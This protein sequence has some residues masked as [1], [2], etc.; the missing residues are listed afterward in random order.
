MLDLFNLRS[1]LFWISIFTFS[2][3]S[4]MT[5]LTSETWAFTLAS[6]LIS[7]GCST[8]YCICSFNL[9]LQQAQIRPRTTFPQATEITITTNLA[10]QA[11]T[12]ETQ[13]PNSLLRLLAAAVAAF[14]PPYLAIKS[15]FTRSRKATGTCLPIDSSATTQYATQSECKWQILWIQR[16]KQFTATRIS[17]HLVSFKFYFYFQFIWPKRVCSN[18]ICAIWICRR[19]TH[20]I[21][22]RRGNWRCGRRSCRWIYCWRQGASGG[23]EKRWCWSCRWIRCTPQESRCRERRTRRSEISGSGC[24][25]SSSPRSVCSAH[26]LH[27]H[28]LLFLSLSFLFFSF[29]FR[30]R[31]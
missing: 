18:W 9:D 28:S 24:V 3:F 12:A 1:T 22:C 15:S 5:P 19:S 21:R 26:S 20:W 16:R 31:M 23:T 27:L 8:Q 13:Y 4:I 30:E 10:S 14:P 2:M 11:H 29:L 7:S 17:F 25:P 6:L